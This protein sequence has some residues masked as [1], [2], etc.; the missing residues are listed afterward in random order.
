MGKKEA[1]KE[2]KVKGKKEKGSKE[3]KEGLA[4]D[5]RHKAF[6][7]SEDRKCT[8]IVFLLLLSLWWVGMFVIAA[9][10]FL[11]GEPARLLYG[12]AYDGV[13]CGTKTDMKDYTNMKRIYYPRLQEDL[14]AAYTGPDRDKF[15]P[16]LGGNPLKIPFT[17]LF[18][19]K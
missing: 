15:D 13:V 7:G 3:E 5:P 6:M 12:V 19:S 17:G 10:G 18:S 14:I 16:S 11:S 9:I 4:H 8:D 2:K 1:K